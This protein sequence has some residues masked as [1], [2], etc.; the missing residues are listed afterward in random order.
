MNII[1]TVKYENKNE[2]ELLNLIKNKKEII[3]KKNRIIFKVIDLISEELLIFFNNNNIE[4]KY[5]IEDWEIN[6]KSLT[7]VLCSNNGEKFLPV[8]TID[9]LNTARKSLFQVESAILIKI[10]WK[11]SIIEITK[12]KIG[13]NK[14]IETSVLYIKQFEDAD[15]AFDEI[16]QK[17][18]HFSDVITSILNNHINYLNNYIK[19]IYAKEF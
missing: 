15:I 6:K 3:Q 13:L 10:N 4:L 9:K 19:P 8:H 7:Q 14:K 5:L 12:N 2:K 1:A 17:F 11:D 18:Y 16:K